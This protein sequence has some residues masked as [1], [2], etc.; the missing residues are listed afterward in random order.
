MNDSTS[1]RPRDQPAD[2]RRGQECYLPALQSGKPEG[3]P[4]DCRTWAPWAESRTPCVTW[5]RSVAASDA[6]YRRA[7]DPAVGC[8][9][10][11]R[12]LYTFLGGHPP[13][14]GAHH[15]RAGEGP[16]INVHSAAVC[17]LL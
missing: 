11:M 1:E 16:Q 13:G 3:W 17:A 8:D 10:S 9:G 2:R 4:T 7:R 14:G 5:R 12:V 15:R 6:H